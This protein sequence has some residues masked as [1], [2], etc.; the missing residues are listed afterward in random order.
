MALKSMGLEPH[1]T[2]LF[3]ELRQ[4]LMTNVI[5]EIG[6]GNE[7]T[8][9]GRRQTSGH[10]HHAVCDSCHAVLTL[11]LPKVEAALAEAERILAVDASFISFGHQLSVIGKCAACQGESA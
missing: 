3:R 1:R 5:E 9:K 8:F 4:L 10:H 11:D 2:T 7:R 6:M